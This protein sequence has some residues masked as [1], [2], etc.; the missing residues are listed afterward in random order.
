[1]R[2]ENVRVG[3]KVR[4]APV[5]HEIG[6]DRI[7]ENAEG[8]VQGTE[9]RNLIEVEWANWDGGWN[10]G[11]GPRSHWYCKVENLQLIVEAGLVEVKL[12][13][14]KMDQRVGQ[15]FENPSTASGRIYMQKPNFRSIP[16]DSP[17]I[18]VHGVGFDCPV[19][20]PQV[21]VR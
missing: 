19:C 15:K 7:P 4:W 20:Y 17:K 10:N 11:A 21:E 2:Y 6:I 9:D 13:E 1:M 8:I 3:Q 16:K 14:V 5:V 12:E 18:C